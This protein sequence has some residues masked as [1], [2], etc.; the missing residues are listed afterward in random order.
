MDSGILPPPLPSVN[1]HCHFSETIFPL[2]KRVEHN[3]LLP[4]PEKRVVDG[5]SATIAAY[6][7]NEFARRWR[8]RRRY[9]CSWAGLSI[10]SAA[11]L[12]SHDAIG[13]A[14]SMR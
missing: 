8:V 6:I 14:A 2:E 9:A 5:S 12:A 7:E 4:H 1:S 13:V 10:A 3:W 11:R